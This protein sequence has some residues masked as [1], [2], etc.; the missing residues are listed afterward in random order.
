M[1]RGS[2]QHYWPDVLLHTNEWALKLANKVAQ[3]FKDSEITSV[4][5]TFGWIIDKGSCQETSCW[6]QLNVTFTV[7]E[8]KIQSKILTMVIYL[9]V[10]FI[11][12]PEIDYVFYQN[13][14]MRFQKQ[15][16]KS[17]CVNNWRVAKN[18]LW[19]R[20]ATY[21]KEM[22]KKISGEHLLQTIGCD[23]IFLGQNTL[24]RCKHT[25]HISVG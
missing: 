18:L 11:V 14:I 4:P 21:Q 2:F 23:L 13:N 6:Q 7:Y 25:N 19:Y 1:C 16:K 22:T 5:E 20:L 10:R 3:G 15:G 24:P 9:T 17:K 8:D 12:N